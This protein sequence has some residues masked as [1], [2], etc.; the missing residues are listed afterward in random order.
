MPRNVVL[1]VLD[2]VRA[3]ALEPYGAPSGA[4]PAIASL[5]AS[6]AA[7]SDVFATACWTL[8]SHASLFTGRLPRALGLGQAPGGSPAGARPVL[9]SERERLL[10]EVLR[11]AGWDTR[12]CSANVWVSETA[13]FS[14]G[15]DVFEEVDTGRRQEELER[16]D[17]RGRLAWAREGLRARADDGAR[18]AEAVLGRWLA[19]PR[20]RPFF[21]FVNLVEAHSPYLPPKPYDDLGPIERIRAAGEARRYLNLSAV[22]RACLTGTLPPEDAL[23]RMRHLYARSVRL[24]DDWVERLLSRLD[25]HGLLDDTLVLV[26]SDHG[27]NFGEDGLMAHAFSLDDRLIHVPFVSSHPLPADGPLSLADVP[28]LLAEQLGVDEH[29]WRERA[30][31]P[32]LAAAQWDFVAEDDPRVEVASTAWGLDDEQSARLSTPLTF[33][34]DGTAELTARGEVHEGD[35]SL[36][37]GLAH[38]GLWRT[39]DHDPEPVSEPA[40]DDIERRMK[41]LGYM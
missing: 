16:D 39:P 31:P 41:L 38:A 14:T 4:S 36:E 11:R 35:S 28:A 8:P 26:T 3:D 6:G 27:E 15:F 30:C 10:P 17:R 33:V 32:G 25:S 29:P 20:E 34:T 1:L 40:S 23:E 18:A 19:E 7:R 37:G 13:G 24:A 12:A 2:T 9:E 21:W 22:W 5:A